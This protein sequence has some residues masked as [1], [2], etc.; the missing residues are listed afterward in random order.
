[1]KAAGLVLMSHQDALTRA[2]DVV[3]NNVAN[4]TT[5]GFKKQESV[6]ETYISRPSSNYAIQF[7][8]DRGTVRHAAQGPL[9]TTGNALDVA[10]QGEG[11]FAVETKAGTLY[12]RAGSFQLNSEGE[13][14]MPNG[15]KLL[16]DGDQVITVPSDVT[17]LAIASDGTIT[18]KSGGTGLQLGKLRAVKFA[19]EQELTA[20]GNN[21]YKTTQQ[22]ETDTE[23]RFVQGMLEQSNVQ[24][25]SEITKMIEVMR[26]YEMS[27]HLLDLDN[28]RQN[29]A[30]T[31]LGK[32]TA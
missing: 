25:V 16:G 18:G 26:S 15:D 1:M 31:R 4:S 5:T 9:L 7:G 11:Y 12:T 2:M 28:Q 6:F 13:I 21:Y 27:V 3:A 8:V 17:D 22:P 10:I 32:V 23:T 20:L 14:V 29:T 24:A 30:I 19:K